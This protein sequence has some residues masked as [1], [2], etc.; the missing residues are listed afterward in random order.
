MIKNIL[1]IIIILSTG[2]TSQPSLSDTMPDLPDSK[3]VEAY[4]SYWQAFEEH[5]AKLVE[6]GKSKFQTSWKEARKEFLKEQKKLTE[7]QIKFLN[8]SAKKYREQLDKFQGASNRPF[9]MLNLAQI[10]NLIGNHY[11]NVD[12]NASMF[13]KNESL[14]ILR[15]IDESFP[16]FELNEQVLYLRAIILESLKQEED[17]LLVWKILAGKAAKSIH[18]VHARIAVGDHYFREEKITSALAYYN[19]AFSLLNKVETD[20]KQFEQIRINYR[21]AWAAHRAAELNTVLDATHQLLQPGTYAKTSEELSKIQLDAIDLMGDA[22]YES[23][24]L[25]I[26]K[27]TVQQK[28]LL[29]FAPTIG[30]RT[31]YRYSSEDIHSEAVKI[32]EYIIAEFPMAREL[33][34]V[35]SYTADSYKKMGQTNKQIET[36]EKLAIMLPA[37]SL[38]RLTQKDNYNT[39]K[40]M[41]ALST[42]ANEVVSNWHYENAMASGNTRRFMVAASYYENLINELPNL[43]SSEKWSLRY[44]HCFY[45]SDRLDEAEKHYSNLINAQKISNDTL[46]IATY[47]LVLTNEKQWRKSYAEATQKGL[48]PSSDDRSLVDLNKLQE[49]INLFTAK[50]PNQ[51]RAIDLLLV[52]ASSNRDM[53]LLNQ[54]SGFWQR[55]LL[56]NASAA[57][58]SVAIRGLVFAATKNGSNAE[59]V[60][61][62]RRFLKLEN[63][64]ELGFSLASEIKS[65]LS[66]SVRDESKRLNDSGEVAR[67]GELL[68]EVADEYTDI[69]ERAQ[70][71]RDGAYMLAIAGQWDQAE[72]AAKNY[73]ASGD[74]TF[75][76][77][78]HYLLG[79]SLQYQVRLSDA[80]KEY[81]TVGSK[82]P[83]HSKAKVS[84]TRAEKFAVSEGDYILAAKAA[85]QVAAGSKSNQS[86]LEHYTRS[87]S[88]LEKANNP[89]KA[90]EVARQR[91]KSSK[92]LAE[93]LDSQLLMSRMLYL[94]GSE[95]EALD[96]ITIVAKKIEK[97][98]SKLSNSEYS[99]LASRTYFILGDEQYKKF[100]DYKLRDRSGSNIKKIQTKSKYFGDMAELFDKSAA[101]GH[102]EWSTRSRFYL[103]N[104]AENFADEI[105]S[106]KTISQEPLGVEEKKK[107]QDTISRLQEMAKRYHSSNILASR[108]DPTA[109]R[110]IS[111][112]KRSSL[113]I[114]S[115]TNRIDSQKSEELPTSHNSDFPS[116]WSL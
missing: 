111:W 45:F 44:A 77:D 88:Y 62:T 109:Y 83:N 95:Q 113:R 64:N 70:I 28:S 104:A 102:P 5:E 82:Y 94:S 55:S 51:S 107:Y 34:Q 35:I 48:E 16:D 17:A 36:L 49:S 69:P 100:K 58:R 89:L 61:L 74:T 1:L 21:R 42:K 43:P 90:L 84:L 31:I 32:G 13:A 116:N 96:D 46:Q 68:V 76:G 40:K 2:L 87:A 110:N 47:Q 30:L 26:F 9:V 10:H 8:E 105:A 19:N 54:A 101:A 39:V 97:N 41:I 98:R 86:R 65:I 56:L 4:R 99:I 73:F 25:Q 103:A 59:V 60:R 50:F 85:N 57:Q 33:P 29:H 79:R 75:A 3:S 92:T 91:L 78:M 112:V 72:Q 15:E 114:S 66:V 12:N 11:V 52:G 71:Y 27:N 63:W 22:L 81:Y 7:A 115:A 18:G 106:L 24:D 20:N 6:E 14:A 37:Q 108:K 23:N 38:W 93:K 53:N 67:G 80:A